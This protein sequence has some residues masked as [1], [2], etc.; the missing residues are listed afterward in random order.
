MGLPCPAWI[1]IVLFLA[2][3]APVLLLGA[4]SYVLALCVWSFFSAV[5]GGAYRLARYLWRRRR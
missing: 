1:R 2:L 3:L 4:V 5:F